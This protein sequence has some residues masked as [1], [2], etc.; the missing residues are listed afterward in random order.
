MTIPKFLGSDHAGNK[1]P[2][3]KLGVRELAFNMADGKIF[4]SDGTK[5]IE[6]APGKGDANVQSDWSQTNTSSDDFIKNKPTI[7]TPTPAQVQSDWNEMSS[8]DKAFIKNKPSIPTAPNLTKYVKSDIALVPG[9]TNV[10]N[11]V[12]MSQHDYDAIAKPDPKTLY[13]I[14]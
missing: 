3:A 7:P 2:L 6:L 9:S 1:P 4:T 14:I 10:V 12:S 13:I 11:M 5:I 8:T